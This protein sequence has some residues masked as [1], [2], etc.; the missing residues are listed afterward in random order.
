MIFFGKTVYELEIED[1]IL[2]PKMICVNHQTF[3]HLPFIFL[4]RYST[5]FPE[6]N[7]K[8]MKLNLCRVCR[9]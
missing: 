3:C 6:E 4:P 1:E 9:V 8:R 7:D 5:I 2:Q